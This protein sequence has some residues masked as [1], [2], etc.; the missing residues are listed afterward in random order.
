MFNLFK[1]RKY[2]LKF[3]KRKFDDYHRYYDY[4]VI[5]DHSLL[6]PIIRL[7][8]DYDFEIVSTKFNVI[9]HNY[10]KIKCK[11]EDKRKIFTAY[12]LELADY[13]ENISY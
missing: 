11:K 13:I 5:T 6:M 2:T 9:G 8:Q 7:Q 4:K 1:Y 3:K 10:I 12:C